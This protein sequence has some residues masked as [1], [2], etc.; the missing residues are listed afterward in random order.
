MLKTID[1]LLY[2]LISM[3]GTF[4]DSTVY[5]ADFTLAFLDIVDELPSIDTSVSPC[6]HPVAFLFVGQPPSLIAIAPSSSLL[7]Y[8]LSASQT[9]LELTLEKTPR[10][11]VVLPITCWLAEL[12]VAFIGVSIGEVLNSF[13]MFEAVLELSLI[14][15]AIDP[16][17]HSIAI[18]TTISPLTYIGVPFCSSPDP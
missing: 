7:P 5:V 11:P 4:H 16:G 1:L 2:G 12:V 8:S 18:G 17:M 15:I 3:P 14:A 10:S 13:S 6:K 9:V